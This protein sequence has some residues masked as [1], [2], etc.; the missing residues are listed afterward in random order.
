MVDQ[1]LDHMD[2]GK[3][4]PSA[5]RAYLRRPSVTCTQFPNTPPIAHGRTCA[6]SPVT[7]GTSDAP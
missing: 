5:P 7:S 6:A 3:F 2:S 4:C 1:R